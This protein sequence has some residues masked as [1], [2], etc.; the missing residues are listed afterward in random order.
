MENY[1]FDTDL[2]EQIRD[3][4]KQ[5][6]EHPWVVAGEPDWRAHSNTEAT[7]GEENSGEN[8]SLPPENSNVISV[9]FGEEYPPDYGVLLDAISLC[10]VTRGFSCLLCQN[11]VS[12]SCFFTELK[13]WFLF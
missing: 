11:L 13:T 4:R 2:L 5:M 6:R 7:G 1:P 12:S 10:F 3:L 8:V 9:E